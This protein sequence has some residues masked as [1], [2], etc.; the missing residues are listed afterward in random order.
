MTETPAVGSGD[1]VEMSPLYLF[2]WEEPQKAYV[3]LFPEGVVKL[4]ETAAAILQLCDG[5][6]TAT[7]IVAELGRKYSAD[8]SD[9]VYK[10]LEVSHAKGWI[11]A[12]P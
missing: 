3:L 1:I 2:R 10:F 8:V 7:E 4:N 9:S 6:R 12:K 11:R 5:N